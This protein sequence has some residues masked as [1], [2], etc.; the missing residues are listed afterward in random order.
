MKRKKLFRLTAILNGKKTPDFGMGK[1][2]IATQEIAFTD[3][4]GR[5]FNGPMFAM[6]KLEHQE[7][8]ASE[9]VS[10]IWEPVRKRRKSK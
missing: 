3:E 2:V 6:A 4:R 7:R 5:G 1:G 9:L 8:L 10:F